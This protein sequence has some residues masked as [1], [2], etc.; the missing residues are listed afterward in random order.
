MDR[1]HDTRRLSP[2]EV[3]R[4]LHRAGSSR[5]DYAE[6]RAFLTEDERAF[7]RLLGGLG[8][9]PPDCGRALPVPIMEGCAYNRC[10]FCTFF[11]GAGFRVRTLEETMGC[12]DE[13]VL[14]LGA[15]LKRRREVF[16]GGAGAAG[17]STERLLAFLEEIRVRFPCP[18]RDREGRARHP[19]G[20]ER[21]AAFKDV[22]LGRARA[23]EEWRELR[24]WGLS[25]VY[26]G[27]ESG[28][29]RVLERLNKPV[30]LERAA[31][32]VA[33]L[34]RSGLEVGLIFL[35]GAGGP[36]LAR[37]HLTATVRWLSGLGLGGR[38][39]IYLSPLVGAGALT[40]AACRQ[41]GRELRQLL[42]WEPP[43]RGPTVTLY[44]IRQFVF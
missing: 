22:F 33:S 16:L 32:E 39:R 15:G 14:R 18:L 6:W 25:R 7:G 31:R 2:A 8:I 21:V 13:V 30:D 37:E 41:Q 27:I 28:S 12:L 5:S 40:P 17:L 38:D 24:R 35:L 44:D 4:W 11:R 3:D 20:F 19:Q 43:P 36:E 34:R 9:L 29:P 1:Y 42:S 10:S 26:L 23:E